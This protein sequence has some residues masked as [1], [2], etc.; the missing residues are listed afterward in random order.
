MPTPAVV[1]RLA[2][3][4]V[5]HTRRGERVNLRFVTSKDADALQSYVRSLSQRSRH[6]RFLGA[7]SE[8]PKTVL[9]D[10]VALGRND[11][12][13]LI[14]T[15]EQDGIESIVA[16]ARYALDRDTGRVEFGLSVQDRWHGHGIGPALIANLERR[17]LGLGAVTLSGDALRTNDVMIALARKAG[18]TIQPHAD[19]WTLVRFEKALSGV[20][21]HSQGANLHVIGA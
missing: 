8:L 6:K 19:D 11:R 20:A 1:D 10:F 7:L 3:S 17:A 12:Y 5:I 2:V 9:E 13:S 16:E 21:A 14:A 15:M 18:F 4:D